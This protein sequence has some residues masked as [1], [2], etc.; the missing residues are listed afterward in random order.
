MTVHF[1]RSSEVVDQFDAVE[2]ATRLYERIGKRIF[3]LA[4]VALIA[5][6]VGLSVLA[7]A[8]VI[9]LDGHNPFF[10][11]RRVG[12]DGKLFWI[13]KLRSMVINS[14]EALRAHIEANPA[15]KAEWDRYQK[16]SNDP[17]I[18][19]IGRIIR[20]LSLDE[21]PQ[22]WNVFTGSMS[23]VG[24]RPMM[25]SQRE[26]YP[27]Q[28]YFRMRPGVTGFWQIGNRSKTTF[29]DRAHFDSSYYAK[30]SFRTDLSVVVRTV[31][32]V[33]KGTGV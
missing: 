10:F 4:F 31:G 7:L 33:I 6:P 13:V 27:G 17:R 16:L 26:L 32:V 20:K 30:L 9:A 3:D 2:R 5:A 19:R 22:F 15:A 28:A 21:L 11:Q 14:D 18:T 25:A 12:R 24:P 8:A 29:A 1:Q 23:V